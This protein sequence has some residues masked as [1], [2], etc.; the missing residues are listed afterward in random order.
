[1]QSIRREGVQPPHVAAT[2]ELRTEEQ[3]W[4]G[5]TAAGATVADW[6][7][8]RGFSAALTGW[9]CRKAQMPARPKKWFGLK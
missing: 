7:R 6:A 1:M 8:Q 3:I 9:F 5:F 4:E 2:Q